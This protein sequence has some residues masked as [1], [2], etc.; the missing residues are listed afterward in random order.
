MSLIYKANFSDFSVFHSVDEKPKQSDF[1]MHI[2]AENE[3]F[4]FISGN[5][6]YLVE[7]NE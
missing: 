1:R 7:G 6:T 2:H 5:A 4:L 3:I